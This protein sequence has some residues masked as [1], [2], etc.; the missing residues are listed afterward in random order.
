MPS[1]HVT[2]HPLAKKCQGGYNSEQLP[3]F[4][5]FGLQV[6]V[7]EAS[8]NSSCSHVPKAT[9][10]ASV[11]KV[12]KRPLSLSCAF[13]RSRFRYATRQAGKFRQRHRSLACFH[14]S[15]ATATRAGQGLISTRFSGPRWRKRPVT[16]SAWC[17][18]HP[19][20]ACETADN[21]AIT[22]QLRQTAAQERALPAGP[23]LANRMRFLPGEAHEIRIGEAW[24]IWA[25]SSR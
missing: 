15:V 14:M 17:I 13:I 25:V 6:P 19:T 12:L 11:K 2:Q 8:S 22:V 21:M 10:A 20:H 9:S 5:K 7:L 23:W 16:P 18:E 1:K 24:R 4:D 3:L